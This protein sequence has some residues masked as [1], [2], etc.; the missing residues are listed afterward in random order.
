MIAWLPVTMSSL[1]PA[2][3]V[4]IARR[5]VLR[6]CTCV[7]MAAWLTSSACGGPE[8]GAVESERASTE[9]KIN[10]TAGTSASLIDVDGTATPV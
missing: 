10:E 8:F 2:P 9:S 5:I 1:A 3:L 6:V 7:P 4:S